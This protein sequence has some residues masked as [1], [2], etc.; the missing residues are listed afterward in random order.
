MESDLKLIQECGFNSFEEVA[1]RINEFIDMM[2]VGQSKAEKN[3][4]RFSNQAKD[5]LKSGQKDKAKKELLKKKKKEEKIKT[6]DTQF[7]VILEK[8]K[9]VKSSTQMLQVLNATK[10][11]NNSLISELKENEED[12][13]TIEGKEYNDLLENGKEIDKYINIILKPIKKPE[14]IVPNIPQNNNDDSQKDFP[15]LDFNNNQNQFK[16]NPNTEMKIIQQCGFNSLGD[17]LNKIYG[18]I[19]VMKNAK[20]KA[21]KILEKHVDK[22]KEYLKVG[23]KDEAKNELK[24]KKQKEEKI[25]DL[26]NKLTILLGKLTEVKNIGSILQVLNAIQ[27]CNM[28]LASALDGEEMGEILKEYP[29]LISKGKEIN[30]YVKIINSFNNSNENQ[31]NMGNINQGQGYNNNDDYTF[32]SDG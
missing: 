6:Y 22:A 10:F 25:K 19:N 11:C 31:N 28:I 23:Q 2:R 12:K 27:D 21:V 32:P 13:E 17:G 9:E 29:D 30:K 4:D 20:E 24:I 18:F 26:D 3:L 7:K 1:K 15:E 14:K 8:L 16:F 5:F